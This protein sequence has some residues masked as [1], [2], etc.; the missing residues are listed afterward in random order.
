MRRGLT[1]KTVRNILYITRFLWKADKRIFFLKSIHIILLALTGPAN[2]LLTK[3]IID[4]L[5][6]GADFTNIV[7]VILAIVLC[8]L[9]AGMLNTVFS[10]FINPLNYWTVIRDMNNRVLYK[11]NRLDLECFGNT[12]FY[13][14]Y[15][16]ALSEADARAN[17]VFGQLFSF[18][19]SLTSL[20]SILSVLL[21]LEP[22]IIFFSLASV[23]A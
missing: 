15:T 19:Q 3:Y 16:R 17:T 18:F 10:Y 12:E 9:L 5:A 6:P 13:N 14:R 20:I 4:H 21:V 11:A 8:S 1:L 22:M 23:V 2:I 7:L